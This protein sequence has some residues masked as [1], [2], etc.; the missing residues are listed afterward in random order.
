[1]NKP[2][3]SVAVVGLVARNMFTG[4][5]SLIRG[6]HLDRFPPNVFTNLSCLFLA[7]LREYLSVSMLFHN[8]IGCVEGTNAF[9]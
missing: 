7:S 1:V 2:H 9:F 8:A 3:L 5:F 6:Q 4:R